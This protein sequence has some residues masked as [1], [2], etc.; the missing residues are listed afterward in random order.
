MD[1]NQSRKEF[2]DTRWM[3]WMRYKPN[4]IHLSCILAVAV[5]CGA[6]DRPLIWLFGD[7]V[8]GLYCDNL[9]IAHPEWDVQCLSVGSERTDQGLT[10]LTNLLSGCNP[11]QPKAVLIE[12]GANDAV[13]ANYD[14][15]TQ[16]MS[17]HAQP[18]YTMEQAYTNLQAMADKVRTVAHGVPILATTLYTCPVPDS[19][20]P[21][22]GDGTCPWLR[23]FS[24]DACTITSL[25]TGGS[26][27]FVD[28]SLPSDEFTDAL[29]PNATGQQI[30]ANRA[31]VAI[32]S[33]LMP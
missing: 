16:E 7:S 14:P 20:T 9:Q 27:S 28:F 29:H 2:L 6:G 32:A 12:E 33:V 3:F 23:C 26:N 5:S 4:V 18:Q 10:R 11:P 13:T 8:T 24:D 30:L 15:V 17:C 25:V 22:L 19:V 1:Q 21:C 31:G